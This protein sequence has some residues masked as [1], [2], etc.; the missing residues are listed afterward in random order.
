[1]VELIIFIVYIIAIIGLVIAS[2]TDLKTREVPD[3]LNY[4][5]IFAGLGIWL[6]YSLITSDFY[7]ILY[8]I[9]GFIALVCFGFFMFY[10]S[11]WGGGDSKMLMAMG[12]LLGFNLKFDSLLLTFV[13]NILIVGAVYGMLWS[14]ALA[15]M[16]RKSFLRNFKKLFHDKFNTRIRRALYAMIILLIILSFFQ[17]DFITKFLLISIGAIIFLTFI[18]YIFSKA[19]EKSCMI[20]YVNPTQLTEGD[21]IVKDIKI[22][23]KYIAGPKDLGIEKKNISKLIK[24]YK[25][26]K[27]KRVL[28]KNGIP[29]VPSFLIAFIISLI[30]GNLFVAL[31]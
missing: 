2:Y 27:I 8:S 20:K 11:Q 29:F 5:M 21:W 28:I 30:F 14:F 19:V 12:A 17:K 16:N 31:F 3:W 7:P 15:L 1:M 24:F 25:Q 6:I 22:N 13:A 26:G 10:S 9:I 18:L 4:S 23:G